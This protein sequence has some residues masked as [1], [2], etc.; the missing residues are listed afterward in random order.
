MRN[1][2]KNRCVKRV[3]LNWIEWGIK[4]RGAD[5]AWYWSVLKQF[6]W[7][8]QQQG[9]DNILIFLRFL[10]SNSLNF[11]S[12]S[13]FFFL[14]CRWF[15]KA[16]Y[17]LQLPASSRDHVISIKTLTN[18]PIGHSDLSN[19]VTVCAKDFLPFVQFCYFD[20]H[21]ESTGCC[22]EQS[23][24]HETQNKLISAHRGS[25]GKPL[26]SPVCNVTDVVELCTKPLLTSDEKPRAILFWTIW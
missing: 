3:Y 8:S 24:A 11:Y 5:H 20:V 15:L 18:H 9:M 7:K 19:T 17:L 25:L 14:F 10:W 6:W 2:D 21:S 1:K 22:Y 13:R 23:L 16:S 12:T 26:P 4:R